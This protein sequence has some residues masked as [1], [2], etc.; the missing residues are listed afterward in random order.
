MAKFRVTFLP[1]DRVFQVEDGDNLLEAA[2]RAGV[3]IN[4][5]CGG[6][7]ACGKCK[8]VVREGNLFSPPHQAISPEEY[9]KGVRLACRSVI[10]S[11][12]TIEVPLE[13]Q[14]DRMA[15]NRPR[16]APHIL[17]P[18]DI[19][20][21]VTGVEVDPAVF[22]RYVEL[23]PPVVED[24]ASDLARL[25]RELKVQHGIEDFSVDFGV[26]KK[27][28]GVVRED[29]WKVTV[30]IVLTRRGYKL[31]NI[32]AGNRA[33]ENYSIVIDIGTTTV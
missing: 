8:V 33:Q 7:G 4:A 2:M 1:M 32:E 14:V 23:P 11:D 12:V 26:L 6:N 28:G 20:Q 10:H 19:G 30:T 9:E 16:T 22:K 17:S 25:T 24:N 31:I 27:L 21:L 3:H 29:S 13:S 5:S 15:L 18:S